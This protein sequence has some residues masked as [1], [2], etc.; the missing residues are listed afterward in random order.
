M[1]QVTDLRRQLKAAKA[2][3][4]V[5]KNTIARRAVKGT[6]FEALNEHFVGTTAIAYTATTRCCWPRR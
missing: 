3:Y 4:K 6:P 2:T 5:V 1:P